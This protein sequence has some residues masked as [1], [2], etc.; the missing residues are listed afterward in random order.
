M[1]ESMICETCGREIEPEETRLQR[2]GWSPGSAAGQSRTI[3]AHCPHC[4]ER[5]TDCR[6][7]Q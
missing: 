6:P 4:G 1:A 3:L 2:S 5:V 7:G